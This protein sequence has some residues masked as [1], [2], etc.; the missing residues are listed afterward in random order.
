VEDV[1][2]QPMITKA[3]F[4]AAMRESRRSVSDAKLAEY[5]T[6]AREMNVQKTKAN[7]STGVSVGDFAFPGGGGATTA[8]PIG[9][10]ATESDDLYG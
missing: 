9:G 5:E 8:A 6:F 10:M 2:E 7:A 3:H 1:V 4:E